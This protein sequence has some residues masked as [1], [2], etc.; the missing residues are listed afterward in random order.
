MDYLQLGKTAIT[1]VVGFIGE[2]DV[3][4]LPLNPEEVSFEALQCDY[5]HQVSVCHPQIG[6][7]LKVAVCVNLQKTGS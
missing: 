7:I 2:I 3:N 1:A 5:Y 6:D 4:S